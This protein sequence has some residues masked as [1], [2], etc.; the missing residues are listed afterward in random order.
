M[1]AGPRPSGLGFGVVGAGLPLARRYV[2]GRNPAFPYE[3]GLYSGSKVRSRSYNRIYLTKSARNA[4]KPVGSML[5]V[6]EVLPLRCSLVDTAEV[7][8]ALRPGGYA[9]VDTVRVDLRWILGSTP[10]VRC[11]SGALVVSP[12]FVWSA[13]PWWVRRCGD[14]EDWK[15]L[16]KILTKILP[17]AGAHGRFCC[18]RLRGAVSWCVVL[19]AHGH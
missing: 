16:T 17:L 8:P 7:S 12:H 13:A 10:N 9:S 5:L 19:L 4:A 3:C 1:F 18:S 15:I 11:H 2:L 14:F 6:A